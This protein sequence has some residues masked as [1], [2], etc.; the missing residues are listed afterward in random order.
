MAPQSHASVHWGISDPVQELQ[1]ANCVLWEITKTSLGMPCRAHPVRLPS[2]KAPQPLREGPNQWTSVNAAPDSTSLR[3]PVCPARQGPTVLVAMPAAWLPF[4]DT[5][6]LTPYQ[7]HSSA[8]RAQMA[9]RSAWEALPIRR[10]LANRVH[11]AAR[12][13]R[14]CCAP[15]ARRVTA[16]PMVFAPSATLRS[17]QAA[18]SWF[19]LLFSSSWPCSTC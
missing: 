6:D 17:M 1:A 8:A 10:G 19:C 3:N 15:S 9:T 2:E 16:K 5:G 4:Q 12:A 13:T 18:S 11:S 14:V 7:L